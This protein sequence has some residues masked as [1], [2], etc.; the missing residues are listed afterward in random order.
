MKTSIKLFLAA[1]V[2]LTVSLITANAQDWPQWRGLNRD[3]RVTGFTPP[4]IWPRQLKQVW[5]VSVGFADATPALVNNRLYVFTR[6]GENEVLQCLDA[7]TGKQIWQSGGYPAIVAS[8]PAASHPGP[9][10]SPA[11]S[12]GKVVT[13]GLGGD[14]ACF[15]CASGKLIWRNEE[16]KGAFPQFYT[17]MS[18]LVSS[19]ICFAHLGG[20][21]TGQFVAFDLTTGSIKWKTAGEG[22]AYGSPVVLTVDGTKQIVFQSLTKL[23]GLDFSDGKLLW[24]YATPVGTGRVQN[25]ASPVTDQQKIYYTGLNNGFNAIEIKKQGNSYTVNKLWTN[26]DFSTS[27]NTPVLKDCFLYG[28]SNKTRLFC[29]N[30]SNGQTAW[31]DDTPHQ[32]FGSVID[33]GSVMIATSSISDL[34]V[35]KPD[36][37]V[38]S[39]LATYK[40]SDNAVYAH[41]VISG[42]RIFIKDSESL[43]LYTTD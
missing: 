1:A 27:Y 37:K 23:V 41:P 15:D 14:I 25:A 4:A 22:P 12:D 40:V 7:N 19:G 9:R 26:P 24:E 8:G 20:P 6:Q 28:L 35:F 38:Y 34:V 32:N 17:G 39:Q 2:L 29:I 21:L 42:N 3:D 5:K 31:S 13:V 36:G 18:P 30:A 16:F 10:S 33:A 43:I 11:V